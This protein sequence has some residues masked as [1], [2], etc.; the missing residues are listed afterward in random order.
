[1]IVQQ[2]F[3]KD[4]GVHQEYLPSSASFGCLNLLTVSTEHPPAK[5]TVSHFGDNNQDARNISMFDYE[6][7]LLLQSQEFY[8]MTDGVLR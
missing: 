3:N 5:Q 6:L 4:Y 1:M 8:S 7:S 2:I